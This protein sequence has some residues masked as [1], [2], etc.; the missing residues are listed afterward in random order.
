[1]SKQ[2]PFSK[3]DLVVIKGYDVQYAAVALE[4]AAN[5][6]TRVELDDGRVWRVANGLLRKVDVEEHDR[7]RQNGTPAA[8]GGGRSSRP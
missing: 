4:D 7:V 1:M 8:R 6:S 3:G 5:G 2:A